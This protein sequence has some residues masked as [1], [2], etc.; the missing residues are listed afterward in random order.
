MVKRISDK[1]RLV[2]RLV[3]KVGRESW[4]GKLVGRIPGHLISDRG[5]FFGKSGKKWVAREKR[6]KV[7]KREK[8][9]KIIEV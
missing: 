6:I 7:R 9:Y 1:G 5:R 3:G 8:D 4:S 2:G